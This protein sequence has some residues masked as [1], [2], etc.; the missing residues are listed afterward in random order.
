MN[1]LKTLEEIKKEADNFIKGVPFTAKVPSGSPN[2]KDIVVTINSEDDVLFKKDDMTGGY[3]LCVK[4]KDG[5]ILLSQLV[6]G[7]L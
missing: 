4:F 1:Y 3:F 6:K 7:A 5:H 2:L